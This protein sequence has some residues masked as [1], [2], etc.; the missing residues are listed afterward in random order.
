MHTYAFKVPLYYLLQILKLMKKFYI[1]IL[2]FTYFL[3]NTANAT[4][5][6]PLIVKDFNVKTINE[7]YLDVSWSSIIES[8]TQKYV[9]EFSGDGQH[10]DS[11][12]SQI[13]LYK[14]DL[15]RNYKKNILINNSFYMMYYRLK[16]IDSHGN[17][18]YS[19]IINIEDKGTNGNV[20]EICPNPTHQSHDVFLDVFEKT[21][22]PI[23]VDI[24]RFSGKLMGNFI[25][26]PFSQVRHNISNEINLLSQGYYLVN[27]TVNGKKHH[28][29]LIV[30]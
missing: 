7:R 3:Q 4:G 19:T 22:T 28:K 6:G 29:Q 26:M 20:I 12:S 5:G 1:L 16:I 13:P 27:I 30:N 8:N 2:S 17:V 15:V 14:D 18:Q 9:I 10:F 21:T 11:V 25:I 24:Y 23:E